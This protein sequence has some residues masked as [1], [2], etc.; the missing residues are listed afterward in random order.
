VPELEYKYLTSL[1]L[2]I[3]VP[4]GGCMKTP[5]KFSTFYILDDIVSQYWQCAY[6]VTWRRVRVTVIAVQKQDVFHIQ[7]VCLS[8]CSHSYPASETH[9]PYYTAICGLSRCT[10]F[11]YIIS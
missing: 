1:L 11:F 8:V 7:S 5:E 4:D 6:R 9:A 10:V 3:A 2:L